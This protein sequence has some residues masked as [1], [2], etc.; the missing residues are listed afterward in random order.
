MVLLVY[1]HA[2]TILSVPDRTAIGGLTLNN[3]I[4]VHYSGR[5]SQR[6]QFLPEL[7]GREKR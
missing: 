3:F 7:L 1:I 5:G 6:E 4:E 2:L